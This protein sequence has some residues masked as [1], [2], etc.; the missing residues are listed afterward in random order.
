MF[1]VYELS[2]LWRRFV[3]C[4]ILVSSEVFVFNADLTSF[5]MASSI[6]EI[7]SVGYQGNWGPHF[8][9]IR[10]TFIMTFVKGISNVLIVT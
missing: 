9:I 3:S 6:I 10:S 7:A 4:C 2:S 8:L 1:V 5:Q